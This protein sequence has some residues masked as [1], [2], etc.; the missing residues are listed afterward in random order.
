[1]VLDLA[2]HSYSLL[3][4]GT[5]VEAGVA[6]GWGGDPPSHLTCASIIPGDF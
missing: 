4:S 3:T 6:V 1:M 2:P 5:V